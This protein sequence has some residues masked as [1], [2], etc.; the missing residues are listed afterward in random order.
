MKNRAPRVQSRWRSLTRKLADDHPHPVVHPALGDELAH[1]G[2]DDREAR[3]G[4]RTT[5]RSA[6]RPACRRRPRIRAIARSTTTTPT[7]ATRGARR[8]RSRATPAPWRTCR[9]IGLRPSSRRSIWRGCRQP[10]LRYGDSRLV[11][12]APGSVAV[13]RVVVDARARKRSRAPVGGGLARLGQVGGTAGASGN[14][15]AATPSTVGMSLGRPTVGAS[16]C[17]RHARR[18]AREH[19]ERRAGAG[20]QRA[21]RDR[22][23]A[24]GLDELARPSAER[25]GDGSSR[26]PPVRPD[27]LGAEHAR[28][29]VLAASS[30]DDVGRVA[31]AHDEPSRRGR[32]R[33]RRGSR[34]GTTA[35]WPRGLPQRAVDHEQR[36]TPASARAGD[37][38]V[39]AWLSASR[40]SRRNHMIAFVMRSAGGRPAPPDHS[41]RVSRAR[42]R[43]RRR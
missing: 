41:V 38:A 26:A 8:R 43:V 32:R 28:D 23:R 10:N 35:G 15:V 6:R 11:A 31:V 36:D 1:P 17:W 24:V 4:P 40:R 2:V 42:L 19:L 30:R 20:A 3:C 29:V 7:P 18:Y 27:V 14:A 5:P 34:R 13:G 25:R 12:S 37:A 33:A 16:R 22:P 39:S 9:A 21:R